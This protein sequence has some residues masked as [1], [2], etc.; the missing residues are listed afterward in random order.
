M[1]MEAGVV[2]CEVDD[3][4][5]STVGLQVL[6][7]LDCNDVGKK[8]VSHRGAEVIVGAEDGFQRYSATGTAVL[9]LLNGADGTLGE[10]RKEGVDGF[11]V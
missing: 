5:E 7:T 9:A 10:G 8:V 6:D 3:A 4:L 1:T 2:V 11:A